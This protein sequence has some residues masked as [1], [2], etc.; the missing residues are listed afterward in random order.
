MNIKPKQKNIRNTTPATPT[1]HQHQHNTPTNTAPPPTQHIHQHR[2]PVET[3]IEGKE[4]ET[5]PTQICDLI[6]ETKSVEICS[7]GAT[8]IEASVHG[9][10]E[11]ES[12]VSSWLA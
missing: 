1:Q 6:R 2:T 7:H 4:K 3:Q 12:M 11:R 9:E 8:Q 10:R 5:K